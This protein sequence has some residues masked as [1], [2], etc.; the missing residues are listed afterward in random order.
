MQMSK[1]AR[2]M[3]RHHK[4]QKKPILN[5]VS[6][7][8]IFTILVFFLL[9]NSSNTHQLP[10]NKDLTLPTASAQK[11]PEETVVIAITREDILVQ[12][13][14]VLRL[15]DLPEVATDE[16]IP[17]LK[18]ELEYQSTLAYTA[19]NTAQGGRQITIMGDENISYEL[20]RQ[21]LKTCQQANYRKIA[22][23]ANQKAK[24]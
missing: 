11:A 1:R 3:E 12:G 8:D 17:A 23:A 13:R 24:S 16:G 6:L 7:M 21:I 20:V 14:R 19:E 2:R 10:S 9:V 4:L 5:L 15:A 22:F 18:Q